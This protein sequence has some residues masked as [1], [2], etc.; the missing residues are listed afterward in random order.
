MISSSRHNSGRGGEGKRNWKEESRGG[1]G[2]EELEG[3]EEELDA[4]K[5]SLTLIGEIK[6]QL[7]AVLT[8]INK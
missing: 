5:D 6:R 4:P 7:N 2:I 3:E 1:E 8:I